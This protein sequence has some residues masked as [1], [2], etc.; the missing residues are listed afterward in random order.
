MDEKV[1]EH[2]QILMMDSDVQN[3]IDN[4]K[5]LS[6][7]DPI[8]FAYGKTKDSI[9]VSDDNKVNEICKKLKINCMHIHEYIKANVKMKVI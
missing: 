5:R 7:Y 6:Q 1:E 3:L 9:V 2:L 8:L 4:K